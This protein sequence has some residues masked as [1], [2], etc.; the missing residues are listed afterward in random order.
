MRF[1]ELTPI[2]IIDAHVHVFPSKLFDALKKWFKEHAWEFFKDATAEEFIQEQFDSGVA[3]LVLMTY[4]HR[5]GIA[6]GLNEF[7][8]G[9]LESFPHVVGFA[10]IHPE[11]KYPKE[12]IRHAFEQCGL[13]GVKM[14][15]HVK[16]VAPDDPSMFPIYEAVA[17]HD[18]I[19]TVHAGREPAI[20]AYGLD[21]RSIT[22]ADR[23]EKVL[24]HFPELKIVVP[25]LGIDETERFYDLMDEYPNLYLDTAMVL[26]PVF[27]VD[28]ILERFIG[29]ADR[30]LYGTDYPQIPHSVETELK[31]LLSLGLG[32]E[33]LRKIL[34]ENARKLFPILPNA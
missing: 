23:M 8:A 18:G 4:A 29:H 20:K 14:H 13:C 15:C 24:R 17:G 22:G 33:I 11:D 2:P 26:S 25:H 6:R 16:G 3:G 27:I 31:K 9:L 10:A 32:E 12:I 5:P 7:M 34:F 19:V 21:V 28:I 1:Q 30:I